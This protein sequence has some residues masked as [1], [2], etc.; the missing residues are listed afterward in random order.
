M[1]KN[2]EM[3]YDV[4][5]VGA[6]PIGLILGILLQRSGIKTLIAEKRS[7]RSIQS[8]ASAINAYSLSILKSLGL[9]E[10]FYKNGLVIQDLSLHWKENR[11]S[12]VDYRRLPTEFNNILCLSQP[13]VEYILEE[14][15]LSLNGEIIR[16][17]ELINFID[18]N[19]SI[20]SYFTEHKKYISKYLVGCDG[21]KSTVRELANIQFNGND[22]GVDL[23]MCDCQIEENPSFDMKT[24]YY[25]V[26]ENN[27]SVIIP[28]EK[29]IHRIYIKRESED[30]KKDFPHTLDYFQMLLNKYGLNRLKINNLKWISQVEF[31]YRL[32][33]KYISGNVFLCGDAAHVFPPLGGLGM[34]TG[35]QD[36]LALAWRLINSIKKTKIKSNLIEYENERR[37]LA[38]ELIKRTVTTA[39]VI[40]RIDTSENIN[41]IWLPKM[42]NRNQLANILPLAYSGL[43]QSYESMT[44]ET[45]SYLVGKLVPCF[46][47]AN[48]N[49]HSLSYEYIDAENFIF[50]YQDACS[51][52]FKT[53]L[54]KYA[55]IKCVNISKNKF[56]DRKLKQPNLPNAFLMRPDGIICAEIN[57]DNTSEN[58]L[59]IEEYIKE[60]IHA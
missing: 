25:F 38:S 45:T 1:N 44:R 11:I 59:K 49:C 30:S 43:S 13:E 37:M 16:N 55:S 36:S 39:K 53:I 29:N 41:S 47:V 27:F 2:S 31:Y 18:H 28:L 24:V 5:I 17:L 23:I 58:L 14:H 48:G 40:S 42:S 6:G 12:H 46:K 7:S 32:A 9:I 52:D 33:E 56:F 8:K 54:K 22:V 50:F 19:H 51:V 4:V 35:F 15:Y 34:N 26:N 60:H 21:V 20:E 57:T 3:N 10:K